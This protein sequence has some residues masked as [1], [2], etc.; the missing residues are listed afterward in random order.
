MTMMKVTRVVRAT[1]GAALGM[2]AAVACSSV[3]ESGELG[4]GVSEDVGEVAGAINKNCWTTASTTVK[5]G[6]ASTYTSAATYSDCPRGKVVQIDNYSPEY[7]VGGYTEVR[8][9]G[10]QPAAKDCLGSLLWVYLFEQHGDEW[11]FI[12][13]KSAH[14]DLPLDKEPGDIER[15]PAQP[16]GP[17]PLPDGPLKPVTPGDLGGIGPGTP[18]TC[19]VPKA[20]FFTDDMVAGRS[21]R[22]AVTARL[23]ST[24][25]P[26][27]KVSFKSKPSTCGQGEAD[28]CCTA[29]KACVDGLACG[30]NGEC[31][32]C[33]GSG[34]LCCGT[35]CNSASLVCESGECKPCGGSG[36]NCCSSDK[37]NDGLT[38]SSGTC[39]KECGRSGQDCCS[40]GSAC[41]SGSGLTC[42]SGTCKPKPC[43]GSGQDCCSSGA[44]CSSGLT[45]QSG[46]CKKPAEPVCGGLLAKCCAG[47]N[48][49]DPV[50]ACIGGF[51][52][53][54]DELCSV[55]G[56]HCCQDGPSPYCITKYHSRLNCNNGLT[57]SL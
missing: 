54:P 11:R 7:A 19:L 16:G 31:E 55:V 3:D 21:Y 10:P 4:P 23:G 22:I 42:Q 39:K 47:A 18:L 34:E 29:G 13:S 56:D 28:E 33:G 32:S 20:Y 26:T 37:C 14:G 51:C 25:G 17:A 45:C 8:W 2:L 35:S 57:C 38:C 9:A 53:N 52:V 44:A 48:P 1:L 43:G 27:Q 15:P 36:Q 41:E 6:F 12:K 24:D 50:F 30:A 40:T 49:C 5:G 46:S